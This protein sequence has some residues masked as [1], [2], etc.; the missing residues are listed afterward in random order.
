MERAPSIMPKG[1][2]SGD[3]D[4]EIAGPD[5]SEVERLREERDRLL[6]IATVHEV[7]PSILHEVK[8][9]LSAI[10]ATAE[11]LVEETD[12]ENVR[13]SAYAILHEARRMKL[14]LDGIGAVGRELRSRHHQAV[15]HA[16]REACA[17]LSTRAA[18]LGITARCSVPDM[19]LLPLSTSVAC[20][21]V[22][23][24]FT[25]AIQACP[26]GGSVE[27][28]ARVTEDGRAFVLTVADTGV[29]M[30]REVLARCRALFF[31]TKPRGTGIGLSF[32]ERAVTE[33]G[34]DMDITSLPGRGTR[35]TLRVP[36]ETPA[37]SGVRP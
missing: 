22:Y 34:G 37:E 21:L 7:L 10:A 8:N 3:A 24:L 18:S 12:D 2:V 25:N 11:L 15:D 6:Q 35:V 28:T 16:I 31:T 26:S 1:P 36:L 9:P 30:T 13:A 17:V 19:P 14:T 5:T 33:A 4:D 27:L 29:G 23:N 20:A 32:C